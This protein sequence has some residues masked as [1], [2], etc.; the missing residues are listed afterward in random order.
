M[1]GGLFSSANTAECMGKGLIR[2][3]HRNM[4]STVQNA[5]DMNLRSCAG[6]QHE[7]HQLVIF[8]I[9]LKMCHTH[10][11]R[12]FECLFFVCLRVNKLVYCM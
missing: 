1:T 12:A 4:T 11:V 10:T 2:P 7:E 5:V 6:A 9:P 8:V 3:L